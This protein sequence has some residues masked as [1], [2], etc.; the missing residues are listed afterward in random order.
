M[1][2]KNDT[3][4]GQDAASMDWNKMMQ[5]FMLSLFK[6][7]SVVSQTVESEEH[8]QSNKGRVAESLQATVR[9]W[10]TIMGAMGEPSAFAH[11]Q[12]ATEMTPDIALGFAQT[13]LQSFT[14]LQAQ[15]GEW[16]Q[17]RGAAL[18]TAD[19]QQLDSELIR[20]FTETYEKEFS[21]YLKVPQIGLGRFHQERSLH[22]VDKL[23]TLQLVLSEFLHMLYLP[24]EK[25]LKSLQEKMVEM[26]EAGPLDEKSK[27]YYNLWIKLLE[28]EYMKLFKQPEYADAMGKTL[29]ALN[30]FVGARQEVV[31]EVL[32]QVNIPTNPDLDELSKEIYL[33]KKR[34]RTLENK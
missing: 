33:L 12:K 34:V 8:E 6:P 27:T 20:D 19:I 4:T 23:N 25:S 31:N 13:C 2:D 29:G 7:W 18:S 16:I 28:G 26:T 21:R 14:G 30:E 9:M 5:E 15:A 10:Q 24:V 32:K 22:A 11:F 1:M 17:K 3:A